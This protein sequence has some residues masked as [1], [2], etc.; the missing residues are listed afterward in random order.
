MR[1]AAP[2]GIGQT[3]M[4]DAHSTDTTMQ[5]N[6]ILL[7]HG[8]WNARSWL[9]PLARRLRR[10]GFEVDVFGYPSVFGGAE[11]AIAQLI[12]ALSDAPPL[13]LVGHSLGGLIGL[14]ALR[15]APRLPVARM[16]CIG[17]PLCGSAA[18]RS[19][20]RRAWS[21]P[22]LGR[23]G[24]LLQNGC[25]PWRG[26]PPVGVVA[27][28][29]A[30]GIGRLLARFDGASDGTVAVAET[31]LPGLADHCVVHASHTGLVFSAAA[32][33]QAAHFLREGRFRHP[34]GAMR[35]GVAAAPAAGGTG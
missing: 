20:G 5:T 26:R 23:S 15:R 1:L 3:A 16:V 7:L 30:R 13:H 10:A 18:A 24:A 19:L 8:I 11:T 17:S 14:E 4:M 34:P 12:E 33:A 32:A 22:V 2:A 25:P 6:R 21:A 31:R 27:G 9:A 35:G 29:V 28:D